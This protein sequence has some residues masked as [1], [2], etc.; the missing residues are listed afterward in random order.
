M[1]IEKSSLLINFK[2]DGIGIPKENLKKIFDPFFTTNRERGGSGLGLNVV[3]NIIVGKFKGTIR[4]ESNP[5]E[6]T[7]FKINIPVEWEDGK[8]KTK[9]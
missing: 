9:E 6:G 2:D 4:C 5:D 8:W 7:E 3:Y 1:H